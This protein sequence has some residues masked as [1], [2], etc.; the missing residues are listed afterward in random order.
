MLNRFDGNV[1]PFASEATLTNRTIFGAETQSDDIDDNLNAD[2]KRGWEIVG[3]NDNPTRE[4]FN[5]MG[6]TLGN[7]ISY[8]YQSGVA[9][10]NADQEYY[11]NSLV[12]GSNGV[13]YQSLSGTEG[14]PNTGN[15]P[16]T[17]DTNWKLQSGTGAYV[18][19]T[20]DDFG[21]VPNGI[22]TVIVK[23]LN[24]GGTFIYD[25]TQS[26]IN[27]GGTIFDGWVRQYSG[28]V[29]VKWF[30]NYTEIGIHNADVFALTVQTSL[31]IDTGIYTISNDLTIESNIELLDGSVLTTPTGNTVIF[32]GG[33]KA[34]LYSCLDLS[35]SVRFCK[36][37]RIYP[38]WFGATGLDSQDASIPMQ[39]TF[40]ACKAGMNGISATTDSA[41]GCTN[42]YLTKGIYKCN[43]VDV[44]CQT[45]VEGES[46]GAIMGGIIKQL[47]KSLP[48]LRVHPYNLNLDNTKGNDSNGI[49]TFYRINFRSDSIDDNQE[50]APIIK[51]YSPQQ[52]ATLFGHTTPGGDVG[53][54]DTRFEQ[55]WFQ[56]SAGSCIKI[57]EGNL[58]FHL[59]GCTF[60]V[61]R[62]GIQ[63]SGTARG[64]VQIHDTQ[65]FTCV[66]SALHHTS[67]NNV[68]FRIFNSRLIGCGNPQNAI[69][70]YRNSIYTSGG[71]SNIEL[72]NTLVQAAVISGSS[73]GGPLWLTGCAKVITRNLELIDLDSAYLQKFI[74]IEGSTLSLI[75][76][77]ISNMTTN[78]L[79]SYTNA[80]LISIASN[81]S[82]FSKIVIDSFYNSN[83]GTVEHIIHSDY[84][85]EDL[86]INIGSIKG[87]ITTPI[88][89][90]IYSRSYINTK[91]I[92]YR[93]TAPEGGTWNTGDIL[94]NTAP[95]AGGSLGWVCTTGGT[96]GTWKTFGTISA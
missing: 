21:T 55:C 12:M 64:E 36:I 2:F 35:G 33:L 59:L 57:D 53:H 96:P 24:R 5:A 65:F 3:L 84:V 26:A 1:V 13:V 60:D 80:R 6:Y 23:D 93:S 83:A 62:Q 20:V 10:Y 29:N 18:I 81:A 75:N 49:N 9:E 74:Y 78:N 19:D 89:N 56:F 17:D 40:K 15:N 61:V 69:A 8:L 45:T 25:A 51:F 42:I 87:N 70:S 39:R 22:D 66:R 31:L 90:N 88:N 32:N 41:F 48:A 67:T 71:T 73:F 72:Y 43:N 27:N 28:A 34:G 38:Q 50:N 77:H 92:G 68:N 54:I 37:N 14:S 44:F 91:L 85:L 46:S 4:D 94:Y 58:D 7:L 86:V 52:S 63:Y 47:D 11:V 30:G 79:M 16:I 82:I 76:I 95:T